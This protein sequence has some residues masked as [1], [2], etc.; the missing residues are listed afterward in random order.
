VCAPYFV[1]LN[2][3]TSVK[4]AIILVHLRSQQKR[5]EKVISNYQIYSCHFDIVIVEV[6][7][8]LKMCAFSV[9]TGWQTTPPQR[10]LGLPGVR[11]MDPVDRKRFRKSSKPHLLHFLF[12]NSL[13]NRVTPY[14]FDSQTFFIN[15]LSSFV[16]ILSF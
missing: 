3:N 9:N 5:T 8:M 11:S 14:F 15:I 13:I 6:A 7:I 10:P 1:K 12:G 2:K 16:N 4:N